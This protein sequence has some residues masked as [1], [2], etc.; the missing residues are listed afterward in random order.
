MPHSPELGIPEV[1]WAAMGPEAQADATR[2]FMLRQRLR[3]VEALAVA[4]APMP[5]SLARDNGVAV[6][7]EEGGSVCVG[8]FKLPALGDDVIAPPKSECA[9]W[10]LVA[11][12]WWLVADAWCLV[13][14]AWWLVPGGWWLVAGGW[15]LVAGGWWL[16]A[17]GWRRAW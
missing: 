13:A 3:G 14:G 1:V 8:H 2:A 15:W 4:K 10:W 7:R 17:G 9:G 16:V 5:A 12:A 11:G 6:L